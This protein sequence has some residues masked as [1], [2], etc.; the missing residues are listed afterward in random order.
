M[1]TREEVSLHHTAEDCWL[2]INGRVYNV[3]SWIDE[4]PGGDEIG[5][6]AGRDASML[7]EHKPHSE[8]ARSLLSKYEIGVI[9]DDA[10]YTLL[11][12]ARNLEDIIIDRP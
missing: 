3:T 2:I 7:F 8:Y 5:L 6:G 1:F 4:H 11:S 9:E 12:P 10:R